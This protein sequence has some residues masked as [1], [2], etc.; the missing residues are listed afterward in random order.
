[1]YIQDPNYYLTQFQRKDCLCTS[2]GQERIPAEDI[3]VF[4]IVYNPR[5]SRTSY[6]ALDIHFS[7]ANFFATGLFDWFGC[8]GLL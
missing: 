5:F 1:M 2:I 8:R 4:Y 6:I 7:E 3:F